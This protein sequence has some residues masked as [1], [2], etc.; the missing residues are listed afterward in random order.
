M[1]LGMMEAC[2]NKKE[3]EKACVC[4]ACEPDV[5]IPLCMCVRSVMRTRFVGLFAMCFVMCACICRMIICF[6]TILLTGSCIKLLTSIFFFSHTRTRPAC[7]LLFHFH[8]L[9]LIA[10]VTRANYLLSCVGKGIWNETITPYSR[11]ERV[12][13]VHNRVY[14][15][16]IVTHTIHL[17]RDMHESG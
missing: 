10:I 2:C 5:I 15:A 9:F 16:F 1:S 14:T 17:A 8:P 3:R 11:E 7:L 4:C 13:A 12:C 6:L